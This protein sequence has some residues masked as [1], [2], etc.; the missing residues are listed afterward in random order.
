MV[1]SLHMLRTELTTWNQQQYGTACF[2]ELKEG[3][4]EP[5][6]PNEPVLPKRPAPSDGR[7]IENIKDK[8]KELVHEH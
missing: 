2:V 8:I 7:K 3:P 4:P 6:T 5:G 1:L